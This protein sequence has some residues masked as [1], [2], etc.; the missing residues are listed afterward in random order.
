MRWIKKYGKN[1]ARRMGYEVLPVSLI[2]NKNPLDD[3]SRMIG[4]G[5]KIIFDGGAHYGSYALEVSRRMPNAEIYCFEPSSSSFSELE[6]R[7]SG[8]DKIKVF[9]LGLGAANETRHLNRFSSD[10]QNSMLEMDAS[11]EHT[12]GR[13]SFCSQ[14]VES[15]HFRTIDSMMSELQIERVDVLKLDLQG[16][17]YLAMNGAR[18]AC[19]EKR[20]DYVFTEIIV[21]PTYKDQL[22]LDQFW[23]LFYELGF[24]LFDIYYPSYSANGRIRQFDALFVR[25]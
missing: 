7:C 22:R 24:Q 17:E 11:A 5:P 3:I 15:C 12:W 1:L 6:K 14:G 8:N 9:R 10:Q 13:G 23:K 2:P 19:G 4:S 21:Q 25:A 18:S 16:A 20:I